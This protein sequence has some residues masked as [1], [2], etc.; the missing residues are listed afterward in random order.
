[1][2]AFSFPVC[3]SRTIIGHRRSDLLILFRPCCRLSGGVRGSTV[4]GL[5][6]GCRAG[7]GKVL[8]SVS[9]LQCVRHA[10]G[11]VCRTK[12]MS[13]RGVRRLRGSDASS[14]VI[15]SSGLTG[16]RPARRVCA[17]G[18]TC[19]CLLSTSSARFGQSVLERYS[20]GRCVAPGLA[21]SRRHALATGRRVLGGCS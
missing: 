8:P 18:G 10:L 12:V 11:R 13:A 15:V 4:D 14:V 6:R 19:R 16:P 1:M 2:T 7:L 9:C 3:G 20:L 21:F 17:I 5:G